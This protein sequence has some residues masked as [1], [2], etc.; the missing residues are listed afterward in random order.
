LV[1]YLVAFCHFVFASRGEWVGE[2]ADFIDF[3]VV[4]TMDGGRCMLNVIVLF[5]NVRMTKL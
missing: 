1:F 5:V 3:L 2:D 4:I